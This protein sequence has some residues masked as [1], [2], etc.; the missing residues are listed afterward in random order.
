MTISDILIHRKKKINLQNYKPPSRNK[1]RSKRL[2]DKKKK[3]FVEP[4]RRCPPRTSARTL[5]RR[6]DG[7]ALYGQMR[8][9]LLVHVVTDEH[10]ARLLLFLGPAVLEIRPA[11]A[12][13][14]PVKRA[15]Q[16]SVLLGD[17]SQMPGERL[18]LGRHDGR[19]E[20]AQP[21]TY[22]LAEQPVE[23]ETAEAHAVDA[24]GVEAT[25]ALD[26]AREV[27][28]AQVPARR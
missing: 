22:H 15:N 2:R 28:R 6:L 16:L 23:L 11:L 17:M 24:Y 1:R 13:P 5:D 12:V 3:K 25:A 9:V 8:E 14:V 18:E 19:E 26:D 10:D 20:G 21:W 7:E 4:A 27:G